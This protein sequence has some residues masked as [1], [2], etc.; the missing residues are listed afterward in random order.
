MQTRCLRYR[1]PPLTLPLW[2]AEGQ[3]RCFI[4]RNILAGWKGV[5]VTP[6]Q[7]GCKA[8]TYEGTGPDKQVPPRGSS[9]G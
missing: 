6:V 2:T 7:G 9:F 1:R 4:R 8:D 3:T 5:L